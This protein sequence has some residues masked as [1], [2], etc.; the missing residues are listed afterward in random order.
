MQF[1]VRAI[2]IGLALSLTAVITVAI[3]ARFRDGPF[4]PFPGGPL[5]RGPL[6]RG[7]PPDSATIAKISEVELQLQEPSRSRLTWIVEHEGALFIP[8]GYIGVPFLKRWPHQALVDGRSTLR[9]LG[10]RYEGRLVRITEPALYR[11]TS[12]KIAAKY[13][14]GLGDDPQSLWIFRFDLDEAPEEDP[15][16]ES[17]AGSQA[18]SE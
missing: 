16:I 3:T 1:A 2:A 6:I 12:A 10:R 7:T 4:G 13:G 11:A 9:V 18:E 14:G 5:K 17:S 15:D 8:C